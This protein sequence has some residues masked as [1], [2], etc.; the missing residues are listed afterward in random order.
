[1]GFYLTYIEKEQFTLNQVYLHVFILMSFLMSFFVLYARNI[2]NTPLIVRNQYAPLQ[3]F[4]QPR[5]DTASTLGK[6][7]ITYH[8]HFALTNDTLSS[9]NYKYANDYYLRRVYYYFE[10]QRPSRTPLQNYLAWDF[11]Q[12]G[13][14]EPFNQ[15]VIDMEYQ[16]WQTGWQYGYSDSLDLS[17]L[18]NFYSFNTGVLDHAINRYHHILGVETGK[19]LFPN[20]Q[21]Q[22]QISASDKVLVDSKPRNSFGDSSIRLKWR[23]DLSAGNFSYALVTEIELPTGN[24]KLATSNGGVDVSLG[25]LTDYHNGKWHHYAGVHAVVLKDP[26]K[27][28]SIRIRNYGLFSYTLQYE[29]TKKIST[30]IQVD[31]HSAPYRSHTILLSQISSAASLGLNWLWSPSA[32][33]QFGFTEDITYPVPDISFFANGKFRF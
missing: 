13:N 4:L 25:L 20:N 32:I 8:S 14:L 11:S 9:P 21:F 7:N 26:F 31:T 17:L 22:F 28:S 16:N 27:N 12:F 29:W 30:L 19:E 3:M 6:G 33:L 10:S 18:V 2:G 23:P 24:P 5:A 15:T 1:M